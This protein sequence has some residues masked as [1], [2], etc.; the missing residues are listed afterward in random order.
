MSKIMHE[1]KKAGADEV[2]ELTHYK[3]IDLTEAVE[4]IKKWKRKTE[5]YIKVIVHDSIMVLVF[6]PAVFEAFPIREGGDEGAEK[7]DL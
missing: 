7:G 4:C 2:V 1:L 5:C 6:V 3:N